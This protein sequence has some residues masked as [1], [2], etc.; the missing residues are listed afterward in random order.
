MSIITR[1]E[2]LTIEEIDG[3][4][5][6]QFD[7]HGWGQDSGTSHCFLFGVSKIAGT[8]DF[9]GFAES[10][11]GTLEFQDSHPI[12]SGLCRLIGHFLNFQN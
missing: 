9:G 10:K 6:I 8:P 5:R 11:R 3:F 1:L 4:I 7:S 2:C 12:G